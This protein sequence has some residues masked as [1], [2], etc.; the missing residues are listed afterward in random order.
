M[1]S[2]AWTGTGVAGLLSSAGFRAC[3][4]VSVDFLGTE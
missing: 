4:S 3:S 1:G 2:I